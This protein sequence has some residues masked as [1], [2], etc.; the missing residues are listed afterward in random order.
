MSQQRVESV[1]RA[2]TLLNAFSKQ[3]KHFTLTELAQ[4][5]GF[6]KSTILRL[7]GSLERFGYL[8]RD[9]AGVYH[10][11]PAFVRLGALASNSLPDLESLVR[12]RLLQLRDRTGETCAFY[13]QDAGMQVCRFRELGSNAL[14]HVIEEGSRYPMTEGAIATLLTDGAP[15]HVLEQV[16]ADGAS[17]ATLAVVIR[18]EQQTRHGV[19]ALTGLNARFD[20]ATRAQHA[21]LLDEVALDLRAPLGHLSGR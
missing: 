17:L 18:D 16:G 4:H 19:I 9:A 15:E 21:Q 12:P 11:G 8:T 7:S 20:N 3:K 6:Y 10:L 2:L 5:S 13:V 14:C 1:E